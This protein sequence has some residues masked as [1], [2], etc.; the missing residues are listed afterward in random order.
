MAEANR[1]PLAEGYRE[2]PYWGRAAPTLSLPREPGREIGQVAF[3]ADVDAVIVGGGYTGMVAAA[4][5][6]WRGRSVAL[7]EKNELGS[8]ASSRNGGMVPPGFKGELAATPTRE[9]G[10]G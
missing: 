4:R 9:G 8:G 7:L 6:A 1:T 3:P 10:G 2:E 5:L